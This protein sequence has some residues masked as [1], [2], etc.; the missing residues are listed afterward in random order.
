MI[1]VGTMDSPFTRRV[2]VSM[3]HYG[4]AYERR[5]LSVYS[6]AA[7]LREINPLGRSP[8]LILDDGEVVFESS[9]IL[10]FLDQQASDD[11]VLIPRAG[12]ERRR[13]LQAVAMGLSLMEKSV[14]L[15]AELRHRTEGT[16]DPAWV[17][18]IQGLITAALDQLEARAAGTYLVDNKLSQA[19]VTA[20]VAFANLAAKNPDL[21]PEARY[22]GLF[23]LL[24]R[25]DDLP[26]F[27]AS[28]FGS[29]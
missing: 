5:S 28:P 22:P 4:V 3:N 12:P 2:M 27:K 7:I 26:A 21:V 25:C 8:A 16:I 6:D 13:V 10:D 15:S 9:F 24:R 29:G 1:L 17:A 14:A 18:R 20:S 23:A 11:L 19:D